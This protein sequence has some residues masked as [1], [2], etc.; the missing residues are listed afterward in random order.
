M[1][2]HFKVS[3]KQEYKVRGHVPR[4]TAQDP[5]MRMWRRAHEGRKNGVRGQS[6]GKAAGGHSKC[7]GLRRDR[8]WSVRVAD[9]RDNVDGEAKPR[10]PHRLAFI[11]KAEPRQQI[12][13]EAVVDTC[14]IRERETYLDTHLKNKILPVAAREGEG[15]EPCCKEVGLED[16]AEAPGRR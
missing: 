5:S 13:E 10:R 14:C 15:G 6:G 16:A 2:T 12:L 8:G 7:R 1:V 9:G 4:R 3:I 11:P